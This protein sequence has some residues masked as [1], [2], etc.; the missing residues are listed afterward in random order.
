[1]GHVIQT[2]SLNGG[3]STRLE[4]MYP[5]LLGL[6]RSCIYVFATNVLLDFFG[7]TT[8]EKEHR[9]IHNA[10]SLSVSIS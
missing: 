2:V 9:K 1:M 10:G 8:A 6:D 3:V 4:G 5:K 7:V